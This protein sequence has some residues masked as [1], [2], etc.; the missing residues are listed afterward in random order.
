MQ[1]IFQY[2]ESSRLQIHTIKLTL[3]SNCEL[4]CVNMNKVSKDIWSC[5]LDVQK[6]EYRYQFC[7]NQYISIIDPLNKE[8]VMEE[9][10]LWSYLNVGDNTYC[11]DNCVDIIITH[12][13]IT[14]Q[15]QN[16]F[17][18]ERMQREIILSFDLKVVLGMLLEAKLG[19]HQIVVLWYRPDMCLYHISQHTIDIADDERGENVL[20]LWLD[21]GNNEEFQIGVWSIKILL[22]G[23]YYTSDNFIVYEKITDSRRSINYLKTSYII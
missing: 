16:Y 7:I 4:Y 13:L 12:I 10:E 11:E 1:V 17:D 14:N 2:R 19:F 6:G 20:W 5:D 3:K 9:G 22:D 23:R 8:R 21:I 15:L 18:M